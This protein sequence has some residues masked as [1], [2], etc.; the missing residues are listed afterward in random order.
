MI[1]TPQYMSPGEAT[2]NNL[3]VD[4]R[5]DLYSL[6]VLL[7]ELLVGSP[8]FAKKELERAGVMEMLRIVREEEPPRPSTK[9][10][11]ADTLS[12][13]AAN[14]STEPKKLTGMLRNELDWI[15]MKAL[16]KNRTRRYDTAN[17]FAADILRYLSGEPVQAVPPSASYRLRKFVRRHKGRVVAG[18]VILL[19][20]MGA[21]IGTTYGLI[22]AMNQRQAN[23]LKE[24]AEQARDGA[25]RAQGAAGIGKEGCRKRTGRGNTRTK[26]CRGSAGLAGSG[27][28]ETRP[29]QL[30]TQHRGGL[31]TVEREQD[32]GSPNRAG[33]HPT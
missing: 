31:S 30:R 18:C 12:T 19:A 14:R 25:V 28:R 11:T 4:T 26:S 24:Q 1:G 6:G 22:E 23:T 32:R 33:R 16:E 17:G 13:L 9:L 2:F 8:P 29:V 10:S 5:S 20:L 21:A 7:Y 27:T 3:D 15:V